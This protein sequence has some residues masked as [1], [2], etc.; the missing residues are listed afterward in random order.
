[1][2]QKTA[3]EILKK[4]HNVFLTGP[5]GSGKTYLLNRYIK[6]LKQNSIRHAVTASTGIAATHLSGRTIHSWA[7]IGISDH[8]SEKEIADILKNSLIK[9][10][11]TK[12]NVLI[13]DEVSMI[14]AHQLDLVNKI[15][16]LARASWE[17]FGGMQ[18]IFSG[19]FFQLPPISKKA[20]VEKKFVYDAQS[21]KESNM[22]I[23]YL[24][25]QFR[26]NDSIIT[27]VLNSVRNNT[28]N[29]DVIDLLR[30]SGDNFDP[31]DNVTRLFTHNIDVDMINNRELQ[32]IPGKSF[33]Y[34][35]VGDGKE[36][37]IT[38]LKNSCLAP[39]NL[40][41]K[42]GALVMFV[43]NNFEAGYVNGTIGTVIDFDED[44]FPIVEIMS[45]EEITVYPEKW[46]LEEN[47]E[48][49]G[50][51][52]QL[53]LRLAWAITVHKS[54]GMTLDAAEID[55]R[56]CFEYGMGYVALSRVRSLGNM[57]LLGINDM[58]LK[59]DPTIIKKDKE[60]QKLSK[61]SEKFT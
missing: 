51:I 47:D 4:G 55:L 7:G 42:E 49:L 24:S 56:K 14:H 9:E 15:L 48:T 20:D 37:V 29:K 25:E 1:M 38:A 50:E 32:K 3:L 11:L 27:K 23:C 19:D 54:Q 22:H 57:R 31:S 17:P 59:V 10:R 60:F 26:H 34:E 30:E 2:K 12:T 35:M 13:I 41:L 40:I 44:G 18:V 8:L 61:K 45:G 53:P 52:T 39:E 5:P 16:R 43:R 33:M 28:V 46:A 6:H 21:W 58:A 36:Y